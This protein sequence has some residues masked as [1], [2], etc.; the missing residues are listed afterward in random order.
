MITTPHMMERLSMAHIHAL[1][2]GAGLNMWEGKTHDYGV[3]ITLRPVIIRDGRRVESGFS[4][5]CQ[6]KA[7]TNW[8]YD[9]QEVIYDLEAKNFNDI[10]GRNADAIP[11]IVI[12]L[13]LPSE[14]SDWMS[15]DETQTVLR[16]CCYWVRPQGPLTTNTS[17][18]RVRIPRQNR[19]TA[20]GLGA[21][22]DRLQRPSHGGAG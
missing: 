17:T 6:V 16:N 3:D 2:G 19:V 21:L 13:C 8:R 11:L 1:S 10:V 7:T 9:D 15:S 4:L 5:D 18:V 12:L 22:V 20:Q 14:F